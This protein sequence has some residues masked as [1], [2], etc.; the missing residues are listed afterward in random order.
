MLQNDIFESGSASPA[1]VQQI[2]LKLLDV[3]DYVTDVRLDYRLSEALVAYKVKM[4]AP[5]PML[6]E[7]RPSNLRLETPAQ[8]GTSVN[9][10]TGAAAAWTPRPGLKF[11]LIGFG[12]GTSGRC[13]GPVGAVAQQPGRPFPPAFAQVVRAR[14]QPVRRPQSSSM[15]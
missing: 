9:T 11:S 4:S 2:K 13:Q 14:R 7:K 3:I 5:P 10:L 12:S 15:P 6:R 8:P 1:I